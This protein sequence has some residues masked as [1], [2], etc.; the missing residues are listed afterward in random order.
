MSAAARR[1]GFT[2]IE[3]MVVLAIL[4]IILM[5]AIPAYSDQVRRARRSEAIQRI[6]DI[7]LA[8]ERWRAEN[9]AYGSDAQIGS[10][11][12]PMYTVAIS[13]QSATDFVITA[14][15]TGDQANDKAGVCRVLTYTRTATPQKTPEECFR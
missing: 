9:P 15:A 4:T 13:G 6:S 14:T 7:V 1:A 2:L 10:V 12:L 5:V 3:L 8:Q 11:D